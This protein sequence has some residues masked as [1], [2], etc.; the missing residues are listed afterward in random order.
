MSVLQD[1]LK[2]LRLYRP[3]LLNGCIG[4]RWPMA[5]AISTRKL[6][7]ESRLWRKWQSEFQIDPDK[8]ELGSWLDHGNAGDG[9]FGI[10]CRICA[11]A[12]VVNAFA[13]YKVRHVG[14]IGLVRHSRRKVH[15]DA[16]VLF[17][18]GGGS[19][20]G[21]PSEQEFKDIIARVQAGSATMTREKDARMMWCLMEGIKARDQA[22]LKKSAAVTLIRDERAGRL[23]VRF[24][25]VTP[26]LEVRS[27]TL[28]QERDHGTGAVNIANAT[29]AIMRRA[30]TRFAAPPRRTKHQPI[31]LRDVYKHLRGHHH[32]DNC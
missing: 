6:V 29:D 31:F 27:G 9:E 20:V 19:G 15:C 1:W 22:V 14:K 17:L 18:Q 30:C 2:Q 10:G 23:M 32:R 11:Q 12:Q 16:L 13:E 24:I 4:Q 28:G 5:E 25:A 21:S 7:D 8:P 3:L 26:S